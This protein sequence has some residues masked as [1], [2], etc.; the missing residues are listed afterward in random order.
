MMLSLVRPKFFVPI[1]GEYRHLTLHCKLA[2]SLGIPEENTLLLEDGDILEI[3]GKAGRIVGKASSG[4]VYVDGL[5]VGNVGR[6]VKALDHGGNHLAEGGFVTAKVKEI[7]G[8]FL[9][10]QT[11]RRPMILPIA[12][13]V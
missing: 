13:E 12:V 7:L 11:K 9:Y 8:K 5:G 4:N 3:D 10:Q 1:H 6:V 2:Q